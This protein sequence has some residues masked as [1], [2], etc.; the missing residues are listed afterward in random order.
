MARKQFVHLHAHTDY[1]LL[2]GAC[3]VEELVS[4]A[5]EQNSPAVAVTDHGNLFGAVKF[6]HHAKNAGINPIIGCEVYVA[7]GPRHS[8]TEQNRYN[9]LVLLCETT[10][11]Y[12]N[13]SKLV[14]AGFLEGFYRKPRVDK[15][16]LAQHSQGLI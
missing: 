13:L 5:V 12:R 4:L 3:G 2:D 10:E 11:G 6:Y 16:L 7:Q 15:D 1:S 9:H 8:R 14:S